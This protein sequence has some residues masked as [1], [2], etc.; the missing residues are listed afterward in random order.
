MIGVMVFKCATARRVDR[1]MPIPRLAWIVDGKSALRSWMSV[2]EKW[3]CVCIVSGIRLL[4]RIRMGWHWHVWCVI[5][6]M[7]AGLLLHA[8]L[9]LH[10]HLLLLHLHL[11][12]MS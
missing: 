7:I 6:G 10:M 11:L 5:G 9:L 12:L 3:R 8:L 2:H 4:N 1:R